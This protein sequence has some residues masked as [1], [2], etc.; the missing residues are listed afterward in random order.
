MANSGWHGF[1]L[2]GTCVCYE[3]G[4]IDTKGPEFIGENIDPVID[5]IKGYLED[6]ERV[7]IMT[8][9]VWPLGTKAADLPFN[10]DRVKFALKA[11]K[12][13]D[14][15]SKETFGRILPT[16]CIKDAEMIDLHDDRAIQVVPNEGK[17]ADGED[18]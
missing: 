7:K 9:R 1:D 14:K 15:W 5:K 16:T 10:A 18:L 6:G 2:D 8:A 12:A 11:K 3:S 13:I 4:D 17:R